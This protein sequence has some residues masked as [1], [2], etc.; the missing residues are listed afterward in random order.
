MTNWLEKLQWSNKFYV[1]VA[2]YNSE[3]MI[4]GMNL[5]L[6]QLTNN[7]SNLVPMTLLI[8]IY[9]KATI[10]LSQQQAL[11]KNETTSSQTQS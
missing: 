11:H 3:T 1:L 2:I 8:F 9:E 4:L 10:E 6:K 7:Y 5:H